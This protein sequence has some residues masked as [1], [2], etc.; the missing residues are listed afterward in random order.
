MNSVM[1]FKGFATAT[2]TSVGA[3]IA[4]LAIGA[5]T[6]SADEEDA[7]RL[8]MAMSDYL[9][10]QDTL[11]FDYDSLHEVV[12]TEGEKLGLANS[13][14]VTIDRPN[15]I[16]ATRHGG[17]SD[18]EMAFDGQTFA[19]RDGGA[20]LMTT[21][22]LPGNIDSLTD[23]L[24]DTYGRPLPAADLLGSAPFGALMS[25]VSEV[26][27]LGSGVIGGVQCDHLAF[28][29][30]EVDWQI[31]IAHGDVPHPCLFVVTTPGV[32]QAPQYSVLIRDWRSD[33]GDAGFT[34][35]ATDG[36]TEVD[37]ETFA[38]TAQ[39]YPDH[40]TLEDTK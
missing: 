16:H 36:V 30:D 27:D 23:A 22:D 5:S 35:S 8:L 1:R 12:T 11:S 31:W 24:R 32:P 14:T 9:A 3:L 17:F 29:A 37:F 6:A 19:V 4:A 38:A 26:K 15:Q 21:L 7:R 10:A 28:R 40:F 25:E 18:V 33:T 20:G 2:A 34:L 39:T 13:G